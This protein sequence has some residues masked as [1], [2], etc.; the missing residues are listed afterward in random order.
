MNGMLYSDNVDD[1]D[2]IQKLST[3]KTICQTNIEYM[4][5]PFKV[6]THPTPRDIY[7]K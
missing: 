2:D 6:H 4:F 1:D 5:W 3:K 7:A